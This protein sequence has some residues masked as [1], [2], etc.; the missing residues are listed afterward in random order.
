[1]KCIH[2]LLLHL[3]FSRKG[4]I[5]LNQVRLLE[6]DRVHNS[7]SVVDR[8]ATT[9]IGILIGSICRMQCV[10]SGRLSN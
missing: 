8:Q 10:Y 3:A 7:A 9:I 5:M 1:M 6:N 2:E 4:S